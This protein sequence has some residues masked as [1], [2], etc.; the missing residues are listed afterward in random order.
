MYLSTTVKLDAIYKLDDKNGIV[1]SVIYKKYL[2]SILNNESIY[3]FK[4]G[5]YGINI[6]LCHNF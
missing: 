6:G 4:P 1:L 5:I 3:Y 2:S